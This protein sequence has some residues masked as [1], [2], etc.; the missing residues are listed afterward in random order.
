MYPGFMGPALATQTAQASK[1]TQLLYKSYALADHNQLARSAE[2]VNLGNFVIATLDQWIG[3]SPMTQLLSP[4]SGNYNFSGI[5]F[6]I[7]TGAR[8]VFRTRDEGNPG[9]PTYTTLEI[10]N[11][12]VAAVYILVVGSYVDASQANKIAGTITL[13]FLSGSM[14]RYDLSVGH[15]LRGAWE[16]DHHRL[17]MAAGAGWQNVYVEHQYRAD[18]PATGYIDMIKIS[19]PN[20]Y[21][22]LVLQR[23][24]FADLSQENMNSLNPSIQIM[25][26]TYATRY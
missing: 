7:A 20:E 24:E 18:G 1:R 26:V 13:R 3:N 6:E 8:A 25:G 16:Y 15:T 2:L 22:K 5:P 23:I 17:Q 14:L 4:I 19:V 11:Y 10:N 9:F 21:D 12:N